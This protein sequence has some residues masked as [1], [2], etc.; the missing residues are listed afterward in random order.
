[1]DSHENNDD[2]TDID[3]ADD[4]AKCPSVNSGC[5]GTTLHCVQSY[6]E[7]IKLQHQ[8]LLSNQN[9]TTATVILVYLLY[10]FCI[11]SIKGKTIMFL[12]TIYVNL[13]V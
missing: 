10:I 11:L 8:Q 9:L 13:L 5:P 2:D 1:M 7:I 3:N 4:V 12:Q 6:A